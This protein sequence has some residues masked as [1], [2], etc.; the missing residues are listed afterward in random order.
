[1][2]RWTAEWFVQESGE[3]DVLADTKDDL[4]LCAG[5]WRL[6]GGKK[7]EEK[8]KKFVG[9][10]FTELGGQVAVGVGFDGS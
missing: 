9:G 7:E 2:L 5:Y 1:M 10:W 3:V 4:L 8:K 6:L